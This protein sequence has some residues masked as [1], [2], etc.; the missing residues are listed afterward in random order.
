MDSPIKLAISGVVAVI[1]LI[2]VWTFWP[3][4]SI[5]AGHQGVVTIFGKVQPE[6][7]SAGLHTVNPMAHVHD[8]NTQVQKMEVKGARAWFAREG[9]GVD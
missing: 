3:L 2:F 7:L 9:A 5:P 4:V 1:V 8:I 6:S